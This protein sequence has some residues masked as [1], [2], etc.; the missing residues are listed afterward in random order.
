MRP[1]R[2]LIKKTR[3]LAWAACGVSTFSLTENASLI[4]AY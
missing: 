2:V 1:H 3:Y 4:Q